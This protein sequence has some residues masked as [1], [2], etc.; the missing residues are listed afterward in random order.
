MKCQDL[1]V[2]LAI[3]IQAICRAAAVRQMTLIVVIIPNRNIAG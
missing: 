2:E 3:L 1:L